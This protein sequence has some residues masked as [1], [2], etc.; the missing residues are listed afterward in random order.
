MSKES[1]ND[2]VFI[3]IPRTGGGTFKNILTSW[4]LPE[5]CWRSRGGAIERQLAGVEKGNPYRYHAGRHNRVVHGHFTF[6]GT[7]KKRFLCTFLRNPIEQV[8]SRWAYHKMY[9][10]NYKGSVVDFAKWGFVNMQ[11]KYLKGSTL[12]DFD[13]VGITERF[14]D[15]MRIFKSNAPPSS[16]EKWKNITD[17]DE[18]MAWQRKVYEG[19]YKNASPRNDHPVTDEEK[20]ILRKMS[21]ADFELYNKALIRFEND[22]IEY[23]VQKQ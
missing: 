11:S 17:W 9:A 7:Y 16:V 23:Q 22:L 1:K 8:I 10:I 6:N 13:F 20:E 4:Y 3:H 21:D 12:N 15:S 18:E 14:P 19:N 2:L 5:N